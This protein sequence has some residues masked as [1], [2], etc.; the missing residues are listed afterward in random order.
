MFFVC[1]F[2]REIGEFDCGAVKPMS[3]YFFFKSLHIFDTKKDSQSL[4]L[5]LT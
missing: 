5:I 4:P 1:L 2:C 3:S